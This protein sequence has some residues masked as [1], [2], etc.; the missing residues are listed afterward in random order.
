M[1]RIVRTSSEA[2]NRR[3][4]ERVAVNLPATLVLNGSSHTAMCLNLSRGGARVKA[5]Q[6]LEAGNRPPCG[7]PA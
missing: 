1:I 3:D 2:A 4:D 7:C 6:R 5:N